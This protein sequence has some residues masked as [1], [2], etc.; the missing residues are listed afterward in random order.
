[1]VDDIATVNKCNTID[2]IDMNV[3]CD[4]FVMGKKLE[5]QVK[6]GKCQYVHVGNNTCTSRYFAN[7]KQL[8]QVKQSKYLAD[9][10]STN[11]DDLYKKREET[12]FGY[13]VS[14]LAMT[15]EL[16]LGYNLYQ[17]AKLLHNSIFV[18]GSII[19]METWPNFSDSRMEKFERIQQH[20]IR[21]TFQGHSK[22]PIECLYLSFGVLPLRYTVQKLSL[23]H[24]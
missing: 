10:I 23:I 3:K 14:C 19:N 9:Y 15:S 7:G 21:K 11:I 12:S 22:T 5:F 20:F 17:I 18:S 16:S 4:T 13:A 6:R 8:E 24:I 2:G 1:M